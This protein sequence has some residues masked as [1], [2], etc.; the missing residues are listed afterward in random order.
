MT[1]PIHM[2]SIKATSCTI[3]ASA[4]D[5][6]LPH[7]EI[8]CNFKSK[9]QRQTR[10][11]EVRSQVNHLEN[12]FIRQSQA[13]NGDVNFENIYK[14][15]KD[16]DIDNLPDSLDTVNETTKANVSCCDAKYSTIIRRGERHPKP[17]FETTL[18]TIVTE[19]RNI[20]LLITL[21]CN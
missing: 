14:D 9:I 16:V 2:T 21:F 5:R 1:V 8:K 3:I 7:P 6:S 11:T 20:V 13:E 17:C 10:L 15:F 12:W 18:H 19:G 4:V